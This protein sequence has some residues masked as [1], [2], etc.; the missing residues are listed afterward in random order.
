M[1]VHREP[2]IFGL[3]LKPYPSLSHPVPSHTLPSHTMATDALCSHGWSLG[4]CRSCMTGN[5]QCA[6]AAHILCLDSHQSPV[7]TILQL[8]TVGCTAALPTD[9]V[10]STVALFAFASLQTVAANLVP[11]ITLA[12]ASSS[13]HI[14]ISVAQAVLDCDGLQ[15]A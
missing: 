5:A 11:A 8:F 10:Q 3:F 14:C 15:R 6:C 2:R 9:R 4:E 1:S 12:R 13:A 7:D